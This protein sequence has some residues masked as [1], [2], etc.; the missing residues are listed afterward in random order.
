MATLLEL[1]TRIATEMVRD[2]LLDDLADQLTLHIERAIEYFSDEDLPF[3]AVV[4]TGVTVASTVTMDIPA[5]VRR[6][7]RLTIPAQYVELREIGLD[8]IEGLDNSATGQP[9]HYCYFNDQIRFWPIPDAVYTMQFT[10]LKQIDAP[11]ADADATT[12]W[13]NAAY[14]LISSRTRMTL[15]RDQFR[16][17]DGAA[18]AM[19]ATAEALS[20]LKQENARRQEM[21]LRGPAHYGRG[22]FNI[23]SG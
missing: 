7:D 9:S 11:T 8:E 23:N 13:T 1:K 20:R 14:D 18:L 10:G 5:T 15:Y 16:D 19:S 21:P 17:P 12:V 4:T 6:I 2:D 22:G 3:N